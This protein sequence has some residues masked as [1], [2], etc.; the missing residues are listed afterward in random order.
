M[1]Q[2]PFE[3]YRIRIYETR[4]Q[5][6]YVNSQGYLERYYK[7]DIKL[8]GEILE[9]NFNRIPTFTR[10]IKGK[11]FHVVSL[12]KGSRIVKTIVAEAFIKNYNRN[13][14]IIRHIDGNYQNCNILNLKLEPRTQTS[15]I[16]GLKNGKQIKFKRKGDK[17]Y[18][19]ACSQRDL[20]KKLFINEREVWCYLNGRLKDLT[21][22][23]LYEFDIEIVKN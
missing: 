21:K 14:F 10:Y 20:A 5:L 17:E 19:L 8:N 15:R 7:K 2:R 3:H 22:S 9:K 18:Q 4:V 6:I 23:Y 12:P 1:K 13:K 16:N 11:P